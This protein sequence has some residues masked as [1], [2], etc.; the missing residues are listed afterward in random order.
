MSMTAIGWVSHERTS[1]QWHLRSKRSR[2]P[3][4]VV[5]GWTAAVNE[6]SNSRVVASV[7]R[8]MP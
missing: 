2:A 3:T 6:R 1:C 7:G 4:Q 5:V 8:G